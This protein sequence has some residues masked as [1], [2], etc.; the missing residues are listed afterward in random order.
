[1]WKNWKGY[2]TF[3]LMPSL[4]SYKYRE[5]EKERRRFTISCFRA[6]LRDRESTQKGEGERERKRETFK[7]EGGREVPR[8]R[9]RLTHLG[10]EKETKER[11]TDPFWG[12]RERRERELDPFE[13]EE[14]RSRIKEQGSC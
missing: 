1:M 8:L 7:R 12:E 2:Q 5:G 9:E 4:C 6:C 10:A 14:Q 11:E 13:R 3:E